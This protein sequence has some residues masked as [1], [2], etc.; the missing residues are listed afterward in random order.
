[1]YNGSDSNTSA[2]TRFT[3][4]VVRWPPH[5]LPTIKHPVMLQRDAMVGQQTQAGT[6]APLHKPAAG[7]G[8][9]ETI[10]YYTATALECVV[11]EEAYAFT[12][13]GGGNSP[14]CVSFGP[15]RL[16]PTDGLLPSEAT[17]LYNSAAFGDKLQVLIVCCNA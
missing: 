3:P 8:S 13:Q 12:E 9:T 6:R 14:D 15:T 2:H 5:L 10:S 7:A 11:D 16:A 1:M 4:L 17:F